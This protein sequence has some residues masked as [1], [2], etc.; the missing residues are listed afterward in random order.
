[1]DDLARLQ[2]QRTALLSARFNGA[3]RVKFRSGESEREIEYRSD[4]ELAAALAEVE[5]RI[6]AAN[7]RRSSVVRIHTSKGF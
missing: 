5:R 6:A 4:T 7:G 3:R 1:M 2:A